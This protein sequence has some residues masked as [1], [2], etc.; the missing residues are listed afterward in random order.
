MRTTKEQDNTSEAE[1]VIKEMAPDLHK[2]FIE[3]RDRLYANGRYD[4]EHRHQLGRL[5]RLGLRRRHPIGTAMP[6]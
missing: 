4:A 6:R 2:E 5:V 3:I 1:R